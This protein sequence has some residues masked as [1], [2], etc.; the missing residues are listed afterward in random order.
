MTPCRVPHEPQRSLA[1][2]LPPEQVDRFYAIWKPLIRFVNRRLRVEPGM[3]S[4]RDD[5]PWDPRPV[6]AIREALW[7]N[8][9]VREA[10]IA[11]NPAGLPAADLAIVESW[12]HRVAGTFCVYRHLKKHSI[13]IKDGAREV[14]AV[15]GL[16]SPLDRVVPFSPCYAKAVLLPFDGPIVYDSLLVPYN[17]IIGPGI[18]RNLNDIYK[19][20]KERE[21]LITSLLPRTQ[22]ASRAEERAGALE[23][24]ARVL[25]AFRKHLFR[26]GLSPKVVERD[27]AT[28]ADF[29][30]GYL[31]AL[32]SP[33][34]LR[35]F[36]SDQVQ[37]YL[38]HLRS[39]G[40]KETQH[41]QS[42]TGL[43]RFFRFL[44]DTERL[45]DDVA[46]FILD[47]L[48]GKET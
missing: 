3:L 14:Y 47:V 5:V 31:A 27:A 22:P 13:L 44:R 23:V 35:D 2:T 48:K 45:D 6:L 16:A 24:N 41:K 25:E 32:P 37:S 17:V 12:R 8:D 40:L 9:P 46:D 21:A 34:S 38:M 29:A 10:F 26:A 36:T 18:R 33:C 20:A 19:D 11:E 15:L 4:A 42:R 43:T 7:A 28:V 30:D 39:A 1:M